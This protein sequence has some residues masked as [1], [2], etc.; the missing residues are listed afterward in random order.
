MPFMN[1]GL[2]AVGDSL[3][4]G[5][6][7]LTTSAALC[8]YSA[9]AQIARALG[10]TDFSYPDPTQPFIIDL[11]NWIVPVAV[12]VLGILGLTRTGIPMLMSAVGLLVLGCAITLSGTALAGADYV[13]TSGTVTFTPGQTTRTVPVTI[14]DDGQDET[15]ETF[16]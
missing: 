11:E 15:K 2:M 13:A 7:S 9:P 16:G 4:Q 12:T 14:L 1:P 10:L 3:F 6:R 5:T 8:T